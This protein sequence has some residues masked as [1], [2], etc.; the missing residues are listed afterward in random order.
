M[1]REQ[2]PEGQK[3]IG[4]VPITESVFK[5]IDLPGDRKL[6]YEGFCPKCNKATQHRFHSGSLYEDIFRCIKC[7]S[8]NKGKFDK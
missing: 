4:I 8:Q 3:K 1:T 2:Q 6:K 5:R 7:K